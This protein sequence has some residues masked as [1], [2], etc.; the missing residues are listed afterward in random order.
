MDFEKFWWEHKAFLI[1]LSFTIICI[2]GIL[3]FGLLGWPGTPEPLNFCETQNMSGLFREPVNTWSNS[4]AVIL[5]LITLWRLDKITLKPKTNS[6][7]VEKKRWNQWKGKYQ[8]EPEN[9]VRYRNSLSILYGVLMIFVG[10]GSMYFHASGVRWGHL[11]D[12][13][14]M[15]TFISFLLIYNLQRL[16]R[17][18][19]KWFFVIWVSLNIFMGA[20]VKTLDIEHL[21]FNIFV[22]TEIALETIL[23]GLSFIPKLKIRFRRDWKM[24]LLSFGLYFVAFIFWILSYEAGTPLC[25]PD[26]PL[27]LLQGHAFW[28]YFAALATLAIFYYMRTEIQIP[29]E[30]HKEA[31]RKTV[32]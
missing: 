22:F 18:P 26:W 8:V 29:K 12:L 23:F 31:N 30:K 5:G 10:T 21:Y 7:S 17:F 19:K 1:G 2:A 24:F 32:K 15:H 6:K 13:I 25:F 9:P 14:S 20:T 4:L 27:S 3:V 28:H 16:F 11:I